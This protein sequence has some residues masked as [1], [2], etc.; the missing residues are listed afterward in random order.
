MVDG[1]CINLGLC[2]FIFLLVWLTLKFLCRWDTSGQED[3]DRL[4]PLSYTN[5]D[6]FIVCF[7]VISPTS[8]ANVEQ[9]WIPEV[10]LLAPNSQI[11]L[12]GLKIDLRGDLDLIRSMQ[13][14]GLAPCTYEDG[15]TVANRL[16]VP[17][18]ECS[19]LTQR[20]LKQVFDL[21]IRLALKGKKNA[22]QNRHSSRGLLARLFGRLGQ[23]ST[24]PSLVQW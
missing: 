21:V 17:Y 13:A 8:L 22:N 19:A 6:V 1:K 14:H 15:M 3:F 7:S 23:A 4:R 16:K 9:K 2:V 11:V 20:G 18:V 5:T 10:R 24:G 12:V